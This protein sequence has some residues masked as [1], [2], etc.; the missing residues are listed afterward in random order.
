MMKQK[1]SK[2]D[3]VVHNLYIHYVYMCTTA[4]FYTLNYTCVCVRV[5]VNVYVHVHV[6][7][8]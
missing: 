6:N 7:V 2:T 5:I 3:I 1:E 8:V 4:T